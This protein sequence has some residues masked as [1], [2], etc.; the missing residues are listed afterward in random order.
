MSTR[1][2]NLG[3][4]AAGLVAGV[5]LGVT[6]FANAASP[7]PSPSTSPDLKQRF[8][9]RHS[10]PFGGN[11]KDHQRGGYGGLVTAIDSDSL[12]V[13]TPQGTETIGLTSSTAYYVGRDKVSRTAIAKGAV[14]RVR[15]ADPRATKK[16]ATVVSVLPAHLEGW[17]TKVDDSSFTIT[18]P[19]GFT[20]T[21]NTNGSTTYAK[22]GA[23]ATRSAI[24]VG[25]LVRAIGKVD[26]DGTTLDATQ[27]AVGRPG[28]GDLRGPG[29]V[30]FDGGPM[31]APPPADGAGYP[32]A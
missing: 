20:R 12:T 15:L 1:R 25:T 27:V 29:G 22:D 19:S 9:D 31:D 7:S 17:V 23:T 6:G 16:V 18:D 26:S 4:G 8:M 11:F 5:A 14:V 2:K 30:A 3:L 13:R 28:K 32:V 21:I 24:T 10:T